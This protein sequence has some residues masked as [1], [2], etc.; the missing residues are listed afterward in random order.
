MYSFHKTNLYLLIYA[1]SK[2]RFGDIATSRYTYMAY[3][4]YF[5]AIATSRY[6]YAEYKQKSIN[7]SPSKNY[8]LFK[9]FIGYDKL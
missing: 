8:F 3:K 9:R 6:K 7:V 4:I 5:G 2:S 1:H